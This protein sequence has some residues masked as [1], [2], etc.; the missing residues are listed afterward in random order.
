MNAQLDLGFSPS[1]NRVSYW[2]TTS[3]RGDEL[4][5]AKVA[6]G[7]QDARVLAIFQR[8][9]RALITLAIDLRPPLDPH[10]DQ[11]RAAGAP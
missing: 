9:G 5:D 3:L 10:P 11:G 4:N 1:A 2:N 8:R 7:K 6:A